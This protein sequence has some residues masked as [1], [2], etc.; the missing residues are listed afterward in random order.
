MK[1]KY[2]LLED[3]ESL[4][5]AGDVV[6]VLPGYA[7]NFLIPK[8]LAL[9][10]S[11]GALRQFEA[12]KEKIQAKRQAEIEKL[13]QVANKIAELKISIPMNVGEDNKLYGSV[14]SYTVAQAIADKGIAVEHSKLI[15]PASIKELGS[16][17][18]KVKLHPEVVTTLV[19]A[20]VKA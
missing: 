17:E 2:I 8:K 1:E 15:M 20:I 11:K 12:R 18:V 7:R 5:N 19:I 4:G 10:A 14:T 3:V 6:A 9:K 13:Q 16:Y